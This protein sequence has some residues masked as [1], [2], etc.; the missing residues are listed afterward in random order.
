[1]LQVALT[2]ATVAQDVADDGLG[3][4]FEAFGRVRGKSDF[5][6]GSAQKGSLDEVM[7][8]DHAAEGSFAGKIRQTRSCN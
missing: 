4:G 6:T 8:E 3:G 2:P 1:M 7:A 5:P